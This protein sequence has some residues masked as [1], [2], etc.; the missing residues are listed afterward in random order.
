[1]GSGNYIANFNINN[2]IIENEGIWDTPGINNKSNKITFTASLNN[3][4]VKD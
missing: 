2:V 3:V 4:T 1:M